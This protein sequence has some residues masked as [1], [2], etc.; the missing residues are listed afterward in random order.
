MPPGASP[1]LSKEVIGCVVETFFFQGKPETRSEER[2]VGATLNH[3][4]QSAGHKIFGLLFQLWLQ[5]GQSSMR[6]KKV[7][8]QVRSFTSHVGVER[9]IGKAYDCVDAW[10]HYAAGHPPVPT[11]AVNTCQRL[12]WHCASLGGTISGRTLLRR[13]SKRSQDGLV[14][15]N[16]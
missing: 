14:S 8:M 9:P 5:F 2:L 6:F 15:F 4:F 12:S 7:L 1:K 16:S 10:L 13:W 11:P 3:G